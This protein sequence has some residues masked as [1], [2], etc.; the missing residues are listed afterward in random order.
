MELIL[1]I[2][3]LSHKKEPY[4]NSISNS[5]ICLYFPSIF[6]NISEL[7]S[8]VSWGHLSDSLL[9]PQTHLCSLSLVDRCHSGISHRFHAIFSSPD[10]SL[11]SSLE[12]DCA[13]PESHFSSLLN[14]SLFSWNISRSFLEKSI[15]KEAKYFSP[16][17]YMYKKNIILPT[18][19]IH[20]AICRIIN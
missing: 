6:S 18:K 9:L 11:L 13:I 2:P 5:P 8:F 17:M 20:L 14:Y 10:L 4:L 7:S 1:Y 12:L 16:S 15:Y 3:K 19:L